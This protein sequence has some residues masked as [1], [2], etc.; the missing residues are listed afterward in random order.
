M[1]ITLRDVSYIHPDKE[2]LFQHISFTVNRGRHIA[3]V[4]DNGSGKSTLL[5]IIAGER[6]AAEGEVVV[7][8]GVYCVPQ[9]F[10]QYNALTVA[11]ALR[12]DGKIAALHAILAGDASAHRFAALDDDWAVEERALAALAWWGIGYL[13]LDQPFATLSGGE[14]T[15]A[16]LAGIQIHEPPVILMDEPTNHLDAASRERLYGFIDDVRATLLIVSH[17][18]TL[19]RRLDGIYELEGGRVTPYGGGYDFYREQK[20]LQLDALKASLDEKEKALRLA[21][22]TAREAAERK[23]KEDV[24]GKKRSERKGIP[25]IMMGGLR[26][27]AE[28]STARL[29]EVHA[30]KMDGLRE[31][32][33]QLQDT[34]PDS[35]QMRPDL[36]STTLHTGKILVSAR[37]VNFSYGRGP[38][39]RTPLDLEI[40]SGDRLSIAGAN[41]S[42]KTTLLRLLTGELPPGEGEVVRAAFSHICI[43]QEYSIVRPDLTLV[44]QLER[45]NT[46]HLKDHELKTLLNRYLF[47]H[48]VWDK[49]CASLSGG[50]KM[51]LMLCCLQTGNSTPDM[52]LLDE[53]TNNLDLRSATI[54]TDVIRTYRGTIIAIS[55][56]RHFLRAIGAGRELR[57]E[58]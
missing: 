6:A 48:A 40:R 22:R 43:D 26:E 36:N 10:G 57:V 38:L 32:I 21:R 13:A 17:D 50:E 5:K 34:L 53:P 15:K 52:I 16:F 49:R 27:N 46:S 18:I 42:G 2:P 24:R 45:F 7:P 29:K 55:H 58:S 44:E 33:K 28:R 25:R 9:H 1:S 11:A 12:I 56:D 20:A 23:Q 35:Q 4:G 19:L 30:G 54:L 37:G 39:W 8:D 47:P 51:R 31:E 41:G 14:K 3:L